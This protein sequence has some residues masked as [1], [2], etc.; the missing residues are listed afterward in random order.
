V[1][2]IGEQ[3]DK[4]GISEAFVA[5]AELMQARGHAPVKGKVVTETVGPW[6]VVLNGTDAPIHAEPEGSMGCPD[7]APVHAAI[8]Y[9]GWLA[10][11]LSPAGGWIAAG[12]GANESTF[13]ED[14][15]A[16]P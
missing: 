10:G 2:T 15:K 9:N 1:T 5:M 12:E 13:I 4:T 14:M 11:V 16:R 7:V 8:F 3:V 6:A